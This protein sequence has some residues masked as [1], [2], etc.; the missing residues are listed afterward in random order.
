[1]GVKR[2]DAS[3]LGYIMNKPLIYPNEPARHKLLDI[4]GDLALVGGFI[5]G[6]II[7]NCPGHKIN[8][9]FARAIREAITIGKKPKIGMKLE[10]VP[11]AV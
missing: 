9:L 1:M 11:H 4:I 10:L 7:A 6:K 2:K 8:N 3:K 5:K